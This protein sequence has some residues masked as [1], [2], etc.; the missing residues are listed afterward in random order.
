VNA[1]I[2][3]SA[4]QSTL[5]RS[6]GASKERDALVGCEWLQFADHLFDGVRLSALLGSLLPQAV[7]RCR[8]MYRSFVGDDLSLLKHQCGGPERALFCLGMRDQ[9]RERRI[10]MSHQTPVLHDI[11]GPDLR[12]RA[13]TFG[14][15]R[16][17]EPM[18][19]HTVSYLRFA[20]AVGGSAAGVTSRI[21][22]SG[23]AAD[24]S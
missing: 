17:N 7:G 23:I 6:T 24:G 19:F 8:Q 13:S 18:R 3:Y 12:E 2:G 15:G 1:R 16:L 5:R 10:S 22:N 21:S 4:T 20:D 11:V 9:Q 14:A